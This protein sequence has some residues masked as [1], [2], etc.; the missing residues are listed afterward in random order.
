MPKEIFNF[1]CSSTTMFLKYIEED[2]DATMT[3]FSRVAKERV[4]FRGRI[5]RRSVLTVRFKE[6]N[7]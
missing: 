1:L 5:H 6:E 2:Y 4:L 7:I 3:I